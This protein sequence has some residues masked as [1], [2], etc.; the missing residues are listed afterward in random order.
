MKRLTS[1]IA[2]ILRVIDDAEYAT[3]CYW[4]LREY[5][6]T[7]LTPTEIIALVNAYKTLKKQYERRGQLIK[8]IKLELNFEN[9]EE[10]KLCQ[11]NELI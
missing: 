6:Q 5:E 9:G 10:V 2:N 4:A 3:E 7:G 1:D 8:S 11:T